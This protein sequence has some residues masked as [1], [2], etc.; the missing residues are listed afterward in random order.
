MAVSGAAS[1]VVPTLVADATSGGVGADARSCSLGFVDD[2]R[3]AGVAAGAVAKRPGLATAV[4]GAG[5]TAS[6]MFL[7][8]ADAPTPVAVAGEAAVAP[9][10]EEPDRTAT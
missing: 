3:G 8:S 10:G 7:A 6:A 4:A 1:E 2:E 9:A 5:A